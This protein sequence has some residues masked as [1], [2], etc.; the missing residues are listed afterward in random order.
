M[1]K[2]CYYRIYKYKLREIK[3]IRTHD[4]QLY[5]VS[6]LKPYSDIELEVGYTNENKTY[7]MTVGTAL[8]THCI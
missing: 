5:T 6:D 1:F 7:K 8:K 4:V 2:A 3:S